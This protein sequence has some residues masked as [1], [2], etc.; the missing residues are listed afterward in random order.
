MGELNCKD[1]FEV[2]GNTLVKCTVDQQ[3]TSA[4]GDSKFPRCVKT[5]NWTGKLVNVV[6][7]M[8]VRLSKYF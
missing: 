8:F 3:W 6:T 1:E 7:A 2:S 4:T 5:S